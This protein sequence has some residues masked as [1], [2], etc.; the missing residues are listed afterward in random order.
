TAADGCVGG[1]ESYSGTAVGFDF[2]NNIVAYNSGGIRNPGIHGHIVL[3]NNI[4]YQNT[5]FDV[6]GFSSG[7]TIVDPQFIENDHHLKFVNGYNPC[8]DA[9]DNTAVALDN[10]GRPTL[11]DFDGEARIQKGI[12]VAPFATVDIGADEIDGRAPATALVSLA[13]TAGTN[14]WFRSAVTITL[15]ASDAWYDNTVATMYP[16]TGVDKTEYSF[17]GTTWTNY[18]GP[19]SFASNGQW[20]FD[21]RSTDKAGNVETVRQATIMIDTVAPA[22]TSTVPVDTATG[23]SRTATLMVNFSEAVVAGSAYGSITLKKGTTSIAF[24]KSISG[25]VLTIAPSSRMNANATYTL[26]VPAAAVADNAGNPSAIATTVTFKT[27]S[28]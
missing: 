19:I 18:D 11:P 25:N 6:Q 16:G 8:V 22:V 1:F 14:G 3:R 27:G 12:A 28:N 17:D 23:V 24:T 15:S 20:L 13:G 2:A 5:P 10:T 9:G 4:F 7:F 21:Y 26:T